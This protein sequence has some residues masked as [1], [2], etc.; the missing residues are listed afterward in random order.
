MPDPSRMRICPAANATPIA[1]VANRIH[2][3]V[4]LFRRVRSGGG[5][6]TFVVLTLVSEEKDMCCGCMYNGGTEACALGGLGLSASPW[7]TAGLA[8]A[9]AGLGGSA[10]AGVTD[11]DR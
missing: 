1:V 6:C 2:A 11:L 4:E 7:D 5:M 3:I 10:G 8:G 9:E